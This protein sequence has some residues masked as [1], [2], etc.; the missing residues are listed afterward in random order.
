MIHFIY[1]WKDPRNSDIVLCTRYVGMTN[2]PNARFD[3]HK[4]LD[5]TNQGKD[6]WMRELAALELEPL[7]EIIEIVYDGKN[8]AY[9]RE[10]YWVQYY[11]DQGCQLLNIQ[12]TPC[13]PVSML[14][15]PTSHV[16][17]IGKDTQKREETLRLVEAC[18]IMKLASQVIPGDYISSGS[19]PPYKI[20]G[21]EPRGTRIL[22]SYTDDHG[23]ARAGRYDPQRELGILDGV[24]YDAMV[25]SP[26]NKL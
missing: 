12:L 4:I 3:R 14:A 24:K 18:L 8:A 15:P 20:N 10:K 9:T 22:I 13:N 17:S 2:N 21:V 6:A 16:V 23:I 5:G 26:V 11:L 19:Y 25:N 7:F 1:R